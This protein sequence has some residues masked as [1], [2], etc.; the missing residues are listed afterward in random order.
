MKEKTKFMKMYYKLPVK[1]RKE[2]VYNFAIN[3]MSLE[4]CRLEITQDTK[5]GKKILKDL[6]YAQNE[7]GK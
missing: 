5:L 6:G 1:A 7:T 2:L 3:P 4:I